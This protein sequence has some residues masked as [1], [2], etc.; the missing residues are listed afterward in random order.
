[1]VT[2][3]GMA[4]NGLTLNHKN[5]A[6]H[7]VHFMVLLVHFVNNNNML[8]LSVSQAKS[9]LKRHTNGSHAEGCGCC[10]SNWEYKIN[11]SKKT[12]VK[13]LHYSYAG[14]ET[15]TVTVVA[16]VKNYPSSTV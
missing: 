2:L 16:R 12:I 8:I 11:T 7:M 14:K 15:I 6:T 3:S 10:W 4:L 1:M 9:Y 5:H 13:H